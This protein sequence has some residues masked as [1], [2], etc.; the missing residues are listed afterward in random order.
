MSLSKGYCLHDRFDL[1]DEFVFVPQ[2]YKS[3]DYN[4]NLLW[5]AFCPLSE[6]LKQGNKI[7]RG[8][9]NRVMY[10]GNFLS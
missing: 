5:R 7:E 8:V 3:N 10:F 2:V 1:V 9:L 6:L 4:V